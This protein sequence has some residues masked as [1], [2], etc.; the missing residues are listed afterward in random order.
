[1]GCDD[2]ILIALCI[3]SILERSH[4]LAHLIKYVQKYHTSKHSICT[5]EVLAGCYLVVRGASL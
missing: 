3:S 1:M 5:H 2:V 4:A